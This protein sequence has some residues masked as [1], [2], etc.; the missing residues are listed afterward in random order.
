MSDDL[1][2]E[3]GKHSV[4]GLGAGGLIAGLMRW[5]EGKKAEERRELEQRRAQEMGTRLALIEQKLDALVL[6]SS[7]HESI[8]ERVALLE[9]S[10][11]S[12]DARLLAL[13]SVPPRR[14]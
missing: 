5:L 2:V 9:Q 10:V 14:K 4:T 13:V 6:S 8:G 1:L 11:R 12:L 3:I 7:R